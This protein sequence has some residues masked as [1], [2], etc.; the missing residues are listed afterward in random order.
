MPSSKRSGTSSVEGH[1]PVAVQEHLVGHGV[2][3]PAGSFYALEASRHAG[4]GDTGG[5]PIAVT[6]CPL[7]NSTV[8]FDRRLDE[9]ILTFGATGKLHLSNLIMYDRE[10][11]SW[12][13]QFVGN[14]IVGELN[15]GQLDIVPSRVESLARFRLRYPHGEVM[16]EPA[17]GEREYGRNPLVGYDSARQPAFYTGPFPQGVAPLE[18]VVVA[19]GQA[20]TLELV[21]SQ[22]RLERGDL[23]ITWHPGQSSPL[24][25]VSTA[26]GR[27]IGNVVVQRRTAAGLV[28]V[29]YN[30]S[31]AFA[32]HAFNR[33]APIHRR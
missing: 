13:Q 23:V 32:F 18:R 22:R 24:D 26:L 20:W 14:A 7:C 11:S 19:G 15:G 30:V 2:L 8:V 10:T 16:L 1:D 29:P 4:L 27:D 6:W 28:D 17:S 9:R 31:F 5:V 21:R 33:K 3:A 25:A 12:W